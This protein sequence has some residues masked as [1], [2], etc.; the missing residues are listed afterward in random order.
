[1]SA[2]IPVDLQHLLVHM[3]HFTVRTTK[4]GRESEM[5]SR[6]STLA[7]GVSNSSAW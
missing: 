2:I 4:K 3:A 1:M 5:Q 6:I 7:S